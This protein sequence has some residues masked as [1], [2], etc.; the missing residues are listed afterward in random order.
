MIVLLTH[1]L[2]CVVAMLER[3]DA[4]GKPALWQCL[5]D[6]TLKENLRCGNA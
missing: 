1:S 2:T 3:Y 5:N 4:E 6:M